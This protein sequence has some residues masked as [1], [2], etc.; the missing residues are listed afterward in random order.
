VRLID[1]NALMKKWGLD[2]A[3]KYG[4]KTKEEQAFSYETMFMYEIADMIEEAPT[5]EPVKHGKWKVIYYDEPS[6][7][8]IYGCSECGKTTG[9]IFPSWNFCPNCGAK[10]G[11]E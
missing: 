9:I 11:G 8:D 3:T 10:M 4:N 5:V 7:C 6:E 2:T 1:A